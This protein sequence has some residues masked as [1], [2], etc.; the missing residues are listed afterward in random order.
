MQNII[1]SETKKNKRNKTLYTITI[2]ALFCNNGRL[3]TSKNEDINANTTP[4]AVT[5]ILALESKEFICARMLF[6]ISFLSIVN[7]QIDLLSNY[8]NQLLSYYNNR[9]I[10]SI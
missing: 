6:N 1:E 3:V 8:Q 9:H 10:H 7:T 2:E 5:K 4:T